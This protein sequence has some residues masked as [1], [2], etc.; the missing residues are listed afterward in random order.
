MLSLTF[1]GGTLQEA[2]G[3]ARGPAKHSSR[4]GTFTNQLSKECPVKHVAT[5]ASP[6]QTTTELQ[7]RKL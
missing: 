5:L 4:F 7:K 2:P 1:T 3:G 6:Q